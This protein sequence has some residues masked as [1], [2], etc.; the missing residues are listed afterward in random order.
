MARATTTARKEPSLWAAI[1]GGAA[2]STDGGEPG[3]SNPARRPDWRIPLESCRATIQRGRR[4]LADR[5]LDHSLGAL[6]HMCWSYAL[7]LISPSAASSEE[8]ATSTVLRAAA[9]GTNRL[10]S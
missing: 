2:G 6:L 8:G 7:R 9:R 5:Q 4:A 10:T 3:K 1:V